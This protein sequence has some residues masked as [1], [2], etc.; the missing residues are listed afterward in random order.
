MPK[1]TH[2]FIIGLSHRVDALEKQV[3]MLKGRIKSQR[4]Q[5]RDLKQTVEYETTP[6]GV[7]PGPLGRMPTAKEMA[8]RKTRR[9]R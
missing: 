9:V 6:A 1:I 7:G 8:Q 2:E 3:E 4:E 5:I